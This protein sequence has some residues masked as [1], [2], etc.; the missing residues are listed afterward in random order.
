MIYKIGICDNEVFQIQIETLYLKQ[1][2]KNNHI[3]LEYINFT[4]PDKLFFF[5]K[6]L[7]NILILNIDFGRPAYGIDL[8]RHLV[9]R[10]PHLHIIFV[11]N[12]TEYAYEAFDMDASGYIL[13]PID[14]QK[15]EHSIL[16]TLYQLEQ[17][18]PLPSFIPFTITEN[19]LKKQINQADILYIQREGSQSIIITNEK[20]YYIYET[21]TSL[22]TRLPESFLRINQSEIINIYE[23]REICNNFIYLKNSELFSIGRTYKKNVMELYL[24]K[25]EYYFST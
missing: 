19:N 22:S 13:K 11:T 1:I 16:K 4:S 17:C 21:I 15:L 14:F 18:H 25:K 2:S 10:Y 24:K 8:A 9:S 7:L 20:K 3:S 6:S 12:H 23:I 5:K